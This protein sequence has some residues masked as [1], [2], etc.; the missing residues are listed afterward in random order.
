MLQSNVEKKSFVENF[1][2]KININSD[3]NS[4]I[5]TKSVNMP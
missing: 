1:A 3:K 2:Q 4:K 5:K